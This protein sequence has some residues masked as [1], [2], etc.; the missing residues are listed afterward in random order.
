MKFYRVYSHS[1]KTLQKKYSIPSFLQIG[2]PNVELSTRWQLRHLY[3][4][5]SSSANTLPYRPQPIVHVLPYRCTTYHS[6]LRLPSQGEGVKW[7]AIKMKLNAKGR[8][9]RR[10]RKACSE[11]YIKI[12]MERREEGKKAKESYGTERMK[13]MEPPTTRLKM[14]YWTPN[15]HIQKQSEGL[16]DVLVPYYY[17]FIFFILCS[18]CS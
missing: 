3:N 16:V 14:V 11:A 18:Y 8:S 5:S 2:I 4:I 7:N 13:G 6:A 1:Y 10:E 12:S 15:Y 17:Y 9:G